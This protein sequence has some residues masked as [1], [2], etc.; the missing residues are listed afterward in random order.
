MHIIATGMVCAVG[1]NAAAACAAMRAGIAGF[2]ELPYYDN[3]GEPV[4]GA[5]VPGLDPNLKRGERLIELLSMAVADCLKSAPKIPLERVP[6]LVGL[7]E[8]GR[9]GPPPDLPSTIIR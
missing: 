2:G 8:T 4:M 1:L 5:V 9:P 6:L 7:P 3:D